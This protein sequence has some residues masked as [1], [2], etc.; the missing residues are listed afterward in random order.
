MAKLTALSLS[1]EDRRQAGFDIEHSAGL[2]IGIREFS[3]PAVPPVAYA[4]DDAVDLAHLFALELD[5]LDA[6]KVVLALSGEPQKAES[7]QRL[8]EL[9]ER[10]ARRIEATN[11]EIYKNARSLGKATGEQGIYVVTVASHGLLDQGQVVILPK[12]SWGQRPVHTGV[13]LAALIDDV[14]R[15]V[16]P[17]RLVIADC[18]RVRRQSGTRDFEETKQERRLAMELARFFC[19]ELAGKRGLA[20]LNGATHDG[21]TYDDHETR[22]GVFTGALIAGLR[23]A[24]AVAGKDLITLGDLAEYADRHVSDWVRLH[25]P[26]H[27]DRCLGIRFE[28]DPHE[29]SHLPL[30]IVSTGQA[31]VSS[32]PLARTSTLEWAKSQGRDECGEWAEVAIGRASLRFRRVRAGKFWMGS[33]SQEDGR[34]SNEELEHCVTISR[35]FWLA[36]TPVTSEIWMDFTGKRSWEIAVTG[37]PQGPAMPSWEDAQDFLVRLSSRL[38]G[39]RAQLPTEAQWE[40]ACRAGRRDPPLDR[41]SL[42]EVAWFSENSAGRARPVGRLKKNP[43]GFYDLLGNVCEWCADVYRPHAGSVHAEREAADLGLAPQ[44][45]VRGGSFMDPA[46]RIRPAAR[47]GLNPATGYNFVGFRIALPA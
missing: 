46:Q 19:D 42:R 44:R 41:A 23:G 1:E 26:E 15:S 17:R 30:A 24:A 47:W 31:P 32:R 13:H 36:E 8:A 27:T 6:R 16:A 2:F 11:D 7:Q 21:Y 45:V 3:D 29:M 4:V 35:D 18:C 20:S 40:Y 43:W 12:N 22:N 38:T 28:S 39:P 37:E 34:D 14:T 9:Q 25:H 5:L 10:G 33:P